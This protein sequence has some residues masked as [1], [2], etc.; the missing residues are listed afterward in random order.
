M[1]AHANVL[2]RFERFTS[3][4]QEQPAPRTGVVPK[5]NGWNPDEFARQQIRGLVRQVFFGNDSATTRQVVFSAVTANTDVGEICER[6]GAALALETRAHI[7]IVSRENQGAGHRDRFS[8]GSQIK[9]WSQQLSANL[10][11][12]PGFGLDEGG[13]QAGTGNYWLACLA[14]LRNEFEYAVIQAPAAGISSEAAMLGQLSDGVILVLEAHS[15]RKAPARKI[16]EALGAQSRIL[17]MVLSERKFPVPDR[18]YRR[19]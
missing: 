1:N 11:R 8:G 18:I 6:V 17:G 9:N 4:Q 16:K 19:L 3:R 13:D 5:E 10:W 7:A 2:H 14:E 15:T 12:V